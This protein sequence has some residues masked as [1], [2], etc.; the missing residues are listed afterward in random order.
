MKNCFLLLIACA[1]SCAAFGSVRAQAAPAEAKPASVTIAIA[2]DSTVATYRE[3]TVQRGWGQLLPEFLDTTRVQVDNLA[4]GGRSTKTFKSEGRWARVLAS[5]AKYVFIQFGHNDSHAKN[6]PE[7]T[8][9]KTDY[10]DYLREYVTTA[11]AAGMIPILVTP[12][13]RAMWKADKV[14]LSEELLPYV[15]A[16]RQVAADNQ[17]PV[18]DLYT[19][20]EQAFMKMGDEEL[21]TLLFKPA[22]DRTHFNEKGARFLAALVVQEANRLVP[23]FREDTCKNL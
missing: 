17:V 5:K 3:T 9:A 16:M 10:A 20:S 11:R 22:T 12:M 15:E 23:A 1:G 2:G 6:H 14:H 7:S 13:H 19:L 8:D 18:I 4:A 21:Q